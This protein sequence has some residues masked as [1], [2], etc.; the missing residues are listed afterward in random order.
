V[1]LRTTLGDAFN[2]DLPATIT[3]DY[4]SI[5][6]LAAFVA[7]ELQAQAE[8]EAEAAAAAAAAAAAEATRAAEAA[9]VVDVPAAFPGEAATA[10][11]ASLV[12][13]VA[14]AV[15]LPS[16]L[17]V[18][19]TPP[20]PAAPVAPA[21]AIV[22]LACRYPTTASSSGMGATGFWTQAVGMADLLRRIPMQRW[23]VEQFYAPL[24]SPDG[25]M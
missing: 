6:A 1:E 9:A 25:T 23:D 14:L 13:P 17:A 4:P 24:P 12:Q 15:A 22:G 20:L 7:S 18:V 2:L 16:Q 8:A 5:S 21:T 19:A 3:F 10:R 11:S